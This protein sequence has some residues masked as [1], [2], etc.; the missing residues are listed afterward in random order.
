MAETTN[1][2]TSPGTDGQRQLAINAQYVKDLSFENPRAPHSLLQAPQGVAPDLQVGVD[3][4]AQG[5]APDV[6]EVVMTLKVETRMQNEVMFVAEL[7]YGAVVSLINTP[8]E[9]VPVALMVETPR[10]IFPYVRSI[11]SD[12]TRDGGY[13]PLMMSPIDF[14]DIYR[15]RIAEQQQQQPAGGPVA[16]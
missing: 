14:A 15:R 4:K 12:V 2:E 6:Y 7:A 1:G 9:D 16:V 8:P 13:T 11:I 3:V 10:I 5:L